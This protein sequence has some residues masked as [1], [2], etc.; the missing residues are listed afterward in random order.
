MSS[1]VLKDLNKANLIEISEMIIDIEYFAFFGT[2]LGLTRESD[3]IE[4]DDD[5]DFLVN[6]NE[7][8]ALINKLKF[9]PFNID[10][11]NPLN[12]TN[13]FLTATRKQANVETT[14]DFY[15]YE[16]N[17]DRDF[18][19]ERWNFFGNTED[20]SFAIHIPKNFIFPIIKEEYFGTKINLPNDKD[21]I[22]KFLYGPN[23][24]NPLKK[25]LEYKTTI[26][27]NKPVL[28]QGAV[29]ILFYEISMIYKTKSIYRIDLFIVSTLK[30]IFK[31]FLTKKKY[32]AIRGFLYLIKKKIKGFLKSNR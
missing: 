25:G 16:N 32:E 17:R 11:E 12:K 8:D 15:F 13:F 2:L 20:P 5:I 24:R 27:N 7:R 23:W 18:I 14:V 19:V 10:F 4:H 28:F 3:I 22:C 26:V 31:S 30:A 29:E 21:A 6:L 9:S 1:P